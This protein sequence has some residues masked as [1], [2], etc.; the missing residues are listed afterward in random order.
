MQII[1]STYFKNY[2]KSSLNGVHRKYSLHDADDRHFKDTKN[3]YGLNPG[4]P[5]RIGGD[6]NLVYIVA[7]LVNLLA[8]N[9]LHPCLF[10][11]RSLTEILSL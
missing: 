6:M 5:V 9:N 3:Q 1:F 7:T 4:K 8:I 2:S 11:C 10:V